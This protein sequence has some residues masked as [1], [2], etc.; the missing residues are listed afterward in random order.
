MLFLFLSFPE[1][2]FHPNKNKPTETKKR[3][4][5]FE[6]WNFNEAWVLSYFF[7]EHF[8]NRVC[9]ICQETITVKKISNIKRHY[10]TD[11]NHVNNFTG[12][13]REDKVAR[14][15]KSLAKK[16]LFFTRKIEENERNTRAS[17]EVTKLIVERVKPYSDGEFFKECTLKVVDIVCREKMELFSAISL[18]AG[19][20]RKRIEEW[21]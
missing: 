16:S 21:Q 1:I 2:F 15:W 10:G 8:G 20:V 5:D 3:E 7:I 13:W 18:L 4:V 17:Y 14:L 12:K 19:T 9:L 11:H 6:C